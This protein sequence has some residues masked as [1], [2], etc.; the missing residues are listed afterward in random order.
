MPYA[1]QAVSAIE[2]GCAPAGNRSQEPRLASKRS[3]CWTSLRLLASGAVLAATATL[4]Y[5]VAVHWSWQHGLENGR[6]KLAGVAAAVD[7]GFLLHTAQIVERLPD[8]PD[9]VAAARGAVPPDDPSVL[10]VLRTAARLTNASIVYVLDATGTTVA[11]TTYGDDQ[12]LTGNVYAFRP[13]FTRA[14]DTGRPQA[15]GALGVTTGQ[16]GLYFSAPIQADDRFLGVIVV[17][18]AVTSV[19]AAFDNAATPCA[20]LNQEGIIFATNQPAWLFRAGVPLSDDARAALRASRQFAD[21]PLHPLDLDLTAP[22]VHHLQATYVPQS[23]ATSLPGWRVV[24]LTPAPQLI[25]SVAMTLI[26]GSSVTALLLLLL[27]HYVAAHRRSLTGL[28]RSEA[29][30]RHMFEDTADACLLLEGDEIIDCNHAAQQMFGVEDRHALLGTEPGHLS[31][32]FQPDGTHSITAA[33]DRMRQA[34]RDGSARFEWTH[35][36]A[37]GESFP[38]EVVLTSIGVNARRLLHVVLRDISERKAAELAMEA[39]RQRLSTL[40]NHMPGLVCFKDGA[41]RWL[42]A[43]DALLRICG[44]SHDEYVGLTDHALARLPNA[45]APAIFAIGATDRASWQGTDTAEREVELDDER[46]QRRVFELVKVPMRNDGDEGRG[47]IIVGHDVTAARHTLSELAATTEEL[48][49]QADEL[50]ESRA[51]AVDSLNDAESARRAADAARQ[52]TETLLAALPVGIVVVGQDHRIRR[53]NATALAILGDRTIGETLGCLCHETI[54]PNTDGQCPVTDFGRVVDREEHTLLNRHGNP[55]PVLKT[56][57]PIDLGGERV[58]LEV[59]LDITERKQAE[60]ELQLRAMELEAAYE[61]LAGAKSEVDATNA[62]L[63]TRFISR[64][65]DRITSLEQAL[66]EQDRTAL[67]ELAHKLK[68]AAGCYGFD[69]IGAAAGTVEDSAKTDAAFDELQASV[70]DL[71]DLCRQIHAANPTTSGPANP[72]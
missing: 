61:Q 33:Q 56:A 28:R 62:E 26:G 39:E 41:G 43:N 32:P 72:A 25:P 63:I 64:L 47:L 6:Q 58:I 10:G 36:R 9:V 51:V 27:L 18:T 42:I 57:L 45:H 15:Y 3:H 21:E 50:H 22:K 68:G 34:L 60:Q 19:D 7:Q 54:C 70:Q 30:F 38:I 14:R 20:L 35:V 67:K 24:R 46:G 53:I 5:F 44:L 13:Y 71:L 37:D 55:V 23:Q 59:F 12:R 69:P 16:R 48:K 52:S 49:R 8:Q 66:A 11:S 40:I 17:K 31:P 29:R 1:S 65:P 4:G 2:T